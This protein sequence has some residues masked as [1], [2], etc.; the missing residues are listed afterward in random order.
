[1][2]GVP[3]RLCR[4]LVVTT[5]LPWRWVSVRAPVAPMHEWG[6]RR[7]F[8]LTP[9][10]QTHSKRL[11]GGSTYPDTL[12]SLTGRSIAPVQPAIM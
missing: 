12:Q 1:M 3:P 5:A 9:C 10:S 2:P 4:L 7:D 6:L 11:K 8:D